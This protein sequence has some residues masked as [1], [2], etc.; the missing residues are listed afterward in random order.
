M[1]I[2]PYAFE[3]DLARAHTPPASWYHDPEVLRREE[4]LVFARTW[5]LVGH[6][7]QVAEPG[8]FLTAVV[9]REPLLIVR[10]DDGVVRA[11]SNVCRHRAGA[12][13]TGA[14]RKPVLQCSY[15][16]WTYGLDGRLRGT[17]EWDGVQDFDRTVYGL[18]SYRLETWGDLLF[19]CLDPSVPALLDVLG[20]IVPETRS[21]DRA[22]WKPFRTHEWTVECNWKVYVDNY[23]EGYHIPIV[24]PGL[25][26]QIDYAR[27]RVEL[28]GLHSR[29]HA[30]LRKA[31]E[32]SLYRRHL[33]EGEEPQA[34]YYW[35]FPNL[36]LNLY[37]DNLQTNVIVPL[38]PERTLTRF[39]W[40]VPDPD[41]P[42]LAE[43]FAESF[44]FS[45]EVQDEDIRVCE[46]VQRGLRA[47]SYHAGRYS[48]LRE[49]GLH[50]F[51]GLL[52]AALGER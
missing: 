50:Q 9:A 41:R 5:Q 21:T 33:A 1:P 29:Q 18:P 20:E 36:M 37:P 10:G 7:S 17:P 38:G 3:P 52:A 24:H 19:V 48:A 23:L 42:G 22:G 11:L 6:A 35:L 30:P 15:H 25:F 13:C 45:N 32:D 44:A 43:D 8:A 40:F 46:A 14:G 51:H 47:P 12:V 39:D 49:N 34:D 31:A 27:Y 16:G 28:R 4:A 2:E 26:K